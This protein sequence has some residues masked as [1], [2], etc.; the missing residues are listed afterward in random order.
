MNKI[1]NISFIKLINLGVCK[2]SDSSRIDIINNYEIELYRAT[3]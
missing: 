3:Q 2:K 1:D